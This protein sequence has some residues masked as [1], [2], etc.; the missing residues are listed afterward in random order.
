MSTIR[1]TLGQVRRSVQRLQGEAQ[2]LVGQARNRAG[3][4]QPT[5][6]RGEAGKLLAKLEDRVTRLR[7]EFEELDRLHSE[8]HQRTAPLEEVQDLHRRITAMEKRLTDSRTQAEVGPT[9]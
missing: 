9:T 7:Q 3:S 8:L 6:L 4:A 5:G 1:Q 2:K